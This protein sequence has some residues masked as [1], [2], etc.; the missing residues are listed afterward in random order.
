MMLSHQEAM[1]LSPLQLAYI[2][3]A[4][5]ELLIREQALAGG[6]G[7]QALHRKTTSYVCAPAQA[8]ALG[9]ILSSLTD[10][11]MELVKRGRNAHAKH[12]APRSASCAEYAA[13][14][15]FEALIGYLHI[16]GD[17]QRM[18]YLIDMIT[19]SDSV[20]EKRKRHA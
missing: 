6:C 3:D 2:G 8:R 12:S 19:Q 15:G 11:E 20:Q 13:A 7:V 10:N 18:T 16:T 5:Y 14:T 4:V 9:V 1:Q 17:T